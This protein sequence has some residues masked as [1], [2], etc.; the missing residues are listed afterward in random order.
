MILCITELE[1]K[2]ESNISNTYKSEYTGDEGVCLLKGF[3]CN[4]SFVL[5]LEQPIEFNKLDRGLRETWEQG[6]MRE[7]KTK[8]NV[9]NSELSTLGKF[10][11]TL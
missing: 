3:M 2:S 11:D 7:N 9:R 1:R 6:P 5:I 8:R 4:V 10:S